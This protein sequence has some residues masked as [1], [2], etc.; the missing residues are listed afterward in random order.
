M[1]VQGLNS[2]SSS[3]YLE[4]LPR[5]GLVSRPG[6]GPRVPNLLTNLL[7]AEL[8]KLVVRTGYTKRW[9]RRKR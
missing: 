9:V 4:H 7:I 5:F 6:V 8:V 3:V 1:F 2:L